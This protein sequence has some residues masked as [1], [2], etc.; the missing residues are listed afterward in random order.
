MAT[1]AEL[2]DWYAQYYQPQ[3]QRRLSD[4]AQIDPA[5]LAAMQQDNAMGGDV[6][7]RYA[8]PQPMPENYI[9]RSGGQPIALQSIQQQG[10]MSLNDLLAKTG[11][12]IQDKVILSDRGEGYRTPYG[13]VAGL[14]SQG[15]M[16][17]VD[18]P[19]A[20]KPTVKQM[21]EYFDM[22]KAEAEANEAGA[23]SGTGGMSTQQASQ[24]FLKKKYGPPP[25]GM[26][27]N[28]DGTTKTIPGGKADIAE[29]KRKQSVEN[30]AS[31]ASIINRHVEDALLNTNWLSTGLLGQATRGIGQ[32]PAF[33]LAKTVDTIKANIGFE[34]LQKMREASPTGGALGQVAIQ[35]LDMLQATLGS[36]DTAQSEKQ[37]RERLQSV[38][39]HYKNWLST[40]GKGGEDQQPQQA[41]AT[42]APQKGTVVKGYV[43]LGGDPANKASWKKAQ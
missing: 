31:K 39:T 32:T 38:R 22:K 3:P 2:E 8:Q 34:E 37:L 15:R 23:L 16:W 10:G 6:G 35:E 28:N 12:R 40:V 4:L 33:D 24:E 21:K 9:Q 30:A 17:E 27:W 29:Q 19:V 42:A 1:L 13:S 25:E 43:F 26:Q 11:A 41:Q 36:L 7:V 14:D 18:K 5:Q 20:P